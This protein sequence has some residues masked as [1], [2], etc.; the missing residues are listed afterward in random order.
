MGETMRAALIRYKIGEW[1]RY[2]QT[3]TDWE[4]EEYPR[5]YR[6]LV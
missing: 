5:L 3:V 6:A 4:V 2:H 1:A